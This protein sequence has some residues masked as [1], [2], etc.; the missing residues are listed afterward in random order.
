MDHKEL[1]KVALAAYDLII[2]NR[3]DELIEKHPY[4]LAFERN[5]VEAF[6]EDFSK[7]KHEVQLD[8]TGSSLSV[9]IRHFN[10]SDIASCMEISMQNPG[11]D[12]GVNVDLVLNRAGVIYVE[13]VY[14]YFQ[15][16]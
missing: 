3:I 11:R 7:A 6:V 2:S 16:Q 13:D 4:A 14:A 5:Q 8:V 1:Y 12:S 15:V 10:D 9:N